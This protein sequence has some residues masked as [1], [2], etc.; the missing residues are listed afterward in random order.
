MPD[1]SDKVAKH[2]TET[3][4]T[5]ANIVKE[6]RDENLGHVKNDVIVL[7]SFE[8]DTIVQEHDPNDQLAKLLATMQK[9]YTETRGCRPTL[10]FEGEYF[11]A[12]DKYYSKVQFKAKH[13]L[14][15]LRKYIDHVIDTRKPMSETPI[16]TSRYVYYYPPTT[17]EAVMG[18]IAKADEG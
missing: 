8:Y 6:F 17:E 4:V 15:V 10:L 12:R 2:R 5:A 11:V 9:I 7:T 18:E 14:D 13:I 16:E 3:V 1:I